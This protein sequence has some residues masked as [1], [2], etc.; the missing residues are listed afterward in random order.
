VYVFCVV[1]VV[2]VLCCDRGTREEKFEKPVF[3]LEPFLPR[4]FLRH[5]D[6]SV[7]RNM[8]KAW[9]LVPEHGRAGSGNHVWEFFLYGLNSLVFGYSV[10][11]MELE[12]CRITEVF[13]GV[14][15]LLVQ[16]SL[17]GTAVR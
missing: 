15:A 9:Y 4:C 14:R 10:T 2:R 7:R 11:S 5:I 13:P 1:T 16:D 12:P 3:L 6:G 8:L 17:T